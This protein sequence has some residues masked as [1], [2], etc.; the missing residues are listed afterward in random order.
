MAARP[1]RPAED[2][3]LGSLPPDH[4][5]RR[6]MAVSQRRREGRTR[7]GHRQEGAERERQGGLP[8]GASPCSPED[9]RQE[10]AAPHSQRRRL[11]HAGP[12]GEG[13]CEVGEWGWGLG[14]WSIYMQDSW[15]GQVR[16]LGRP[17]FGWASFVL[18][19]PLSCL[20]GSPFRVVFVLALRAEIVAQT[21]PII[22]SCRH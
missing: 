13:G 14:F 16:G 21:R 20:N 19:G 4:A 15:A 6:H 5:R 1:P 9:G 17:V 3:E 8:A 12:R 10:D 11:R 22:V 18:N 2:A 7:E